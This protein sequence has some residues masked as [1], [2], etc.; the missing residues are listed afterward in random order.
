MKEYPA[1]IISK[2]IASLQKAF[3]DRGIVVNNV[4]NVEDL[5][6]FIQ[7]FSNVMTGRVIVLSDLALLGNYKSRILKFIEEQKSPIV[8]LSS[9][10]S[11]PRVLMSR[12]MT[13]IKHPTI[14]KNEGDS[15][16]YLK[17][18]LE[19]DP[20][21]VESTFDFITDQNLTKYCPSGSECMYYLKRSNIA[22]KRKVASLIFGEA[23]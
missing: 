5:R 11:I 15:W 6:K 1:L 14:V 10:D 20:S 8:C 21:E 4:K 23:A 2:D 19:S 7:K 16:G 13:I 17:S 22:S 3:Y 18:L 12:F 9:Q